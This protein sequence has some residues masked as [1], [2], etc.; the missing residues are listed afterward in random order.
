MD[1][2]RHRHYLDPTPVR[3]ARQF[4]AVVALAIYLAYL[5]YRARYTLNPAAPVF[6]MA[7]YLAEVHGF[8]SLFFYFFQI[9]APCR[10]E[11][12]TPSGQFTVDDA[13]IGRHLNR[14]PRQFEVRAAAFLLGFSER[15][16]AYFSPSAFG[17]LD[18]EAAFLQWCGQGAAVR[19]GRFALRGR[20]GSGVDTDGVPYVLAGGGFVVP[21]AGPLALA[22]EGRWTS[23]RVYQA[24]TGTV[25]LR[26]GTGGG[27]DVPSRTR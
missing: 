18:V 6:A 12:P 15:T 11:C 8:L 1:A 4:V 9:W 19:D 14:G 21:L 25:G 10:R 7:V 26:V 27:Q 22:G 16:S 23:S 20:V 5:I 2:D 24:W 3:L 13:S 17:R